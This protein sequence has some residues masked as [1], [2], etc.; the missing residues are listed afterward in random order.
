[1]NWDFKHKIYTFYGFAQ[2]KETEINFEESLLIESIYVTEGEFVK[3]GDT[4][5]VATRHQE[6]DEVKINDA[7]YDIETIRRAE[8]AKKLDIQSAIRRLEAQKL[9]KAVEIES[10]IR[11]LKAEMDLKL[12]KVSYYAQRVICQSKKSEDDYLGLIACYFPDLVNE[13]FQA[14]L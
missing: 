8:S 14:S 11:T 6:L 1:M 3:E 9:N 13:E 7:T 2:N 5:L 12:N 10:K 4:L